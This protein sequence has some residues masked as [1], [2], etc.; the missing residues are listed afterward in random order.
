MGTRR[1]QTQSLVR[2]LVREF[3]QEVGEAEPHATTVVVL[4]SGVLMCQS[5]CGRPL[6]SLVGSSGV[7]IQ[8]RVMHPASWTRDTT[9][10]AWQRTS[11]LNFSSL[12][13]EN[14]HCKF[15]V[16]AL[17]HCVADSFI[18]PHGSARRPAL[19]VLLIAESS[20]R[21]NQ[22]PVMLEPVD[23]PPFAFIFSL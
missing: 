14:T 20:R 10:P 7:T 11:G 6:D 17:P 1:R 9:K 22:K 3:S 19:S 5:L 13:N 15:G 16:D 4:G 2:G 8:P 18:P 21:N 12:R 23:F